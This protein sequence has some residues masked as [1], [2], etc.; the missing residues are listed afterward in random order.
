M[1]I[2]ELLSDE[3]LTECFDGVT[4]IDLVRKIIDIAQLENLLDEEEFADQFSF[5]LRHYIG[6]CSQEEYKEAY[7]NN[8]DWGY[9]IA[10]NINDML[11]NK[12]TE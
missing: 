1:K 5:H 2:N 3:E 10:S 9:N 11:V 12:W 7:Q 4:N 6:E 8:W